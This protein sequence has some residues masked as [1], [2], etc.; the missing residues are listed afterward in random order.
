MG[1]TVASFEQDIISRVNLAW[2]R[3]K[4]HALETLKGIVDHKIF[5][6]FPHGRSK[7]PK[8]NMTLSDALE[9]MNQVENVRY[10]AISNVEEYESMT[11][12]RSKMPSHVELV[13]KIETKRGVNNLQRIIEGAQTKTVMLD[14]EDLYNDV[15]KDVELFEM[16]IKLARND[17]TKNG[18]TLLELRGVV[19][20]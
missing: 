1:I 9:L 4:H 6:D 19:F 12:L 18:A 16:C 17:A 14:K 13:P 2:M 7:P 3:D 10:F 8:P 15:N 5:L 11:D 20:S